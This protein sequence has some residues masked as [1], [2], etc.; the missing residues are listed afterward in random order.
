MCPI[1]E[2]EGCKSCVRVK[3]RCLTGGWSADLTYNSS[4]GTDG[5]ADR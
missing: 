4:V 3:G 2:G 5:M 1:A